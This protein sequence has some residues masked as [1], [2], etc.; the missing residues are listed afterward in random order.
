MCELYV[1]ADPI[2]YESRSRSLRIRGVVTT[3]RLENQFWDILTEIAAADSVSTNQLIAKLYEE[4]MDY[5]GE[6]VNFASFL[7]VSCTRYLSQKQVTN[8]VVPL[9]IAAG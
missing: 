6:V 1:K 5:R 3:L 4:V 2:L 7:R 8:R 9:S